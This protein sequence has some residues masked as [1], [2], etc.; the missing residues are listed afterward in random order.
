M[1]NFKI[2]G[3]AILSL[4]IFS[5]DSDDDGNPDELN[6]ATLVGTYNVT[7]FNASGTDIDSSGGTTVTETFTII[8]SDF[9][10]ATFTFTENGTITTPGTF[11]ITTVNILNGVTDTDVDITDVDLAGTYQLSGNSLILS[12]SDGATATIQNFSRNGMDL[13]LEISDIDAD[14]S[15]V[16]EGTYTLV[17]Q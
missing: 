12:N 10:N 5:C 16:A 9:N 4:F 13:F 2:L 3:L 11:T 15:Y 1:K 7:A 17:R 8:G 14:G 6:N